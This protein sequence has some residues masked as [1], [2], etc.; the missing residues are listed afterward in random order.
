MPH[1]SLPALARSVKVLPPSASPWSPVASSAVVA[2]ALAA[3]APGADLK[4]FEATLASQDSA[5]SALEQWCAVRRIAEPPRISAHN[6]GATSNDPPID[7]RRQL[8]IEPSQTLA[9]RHVRLSCGR[10]ALSVAWNWYVPDRLTPQMR[11]ML[12][13]SDTP[14]GKVAAPLRFRREPLATIPGRG[15]ACPR[16]TISTHRARLVLPNGQPLAYVVECYRAANLATKR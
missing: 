6:L 10:I 9:L 16:G 14:F 1:S 12:R 5:T 4:A 8:A 7:L 11:E 13:T 3:A 15:E 2:L